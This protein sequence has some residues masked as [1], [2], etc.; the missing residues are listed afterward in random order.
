MCD[1]V[2][3]NQCQWPSLLELLDGTCSWAVDGSWTLTQGSRPAAASHATT[4]HLRRAA[5]PL[6]RHSADFLALL[7]DCSGHCHFRSAASAHFIMQQL[8]AEYCLPCNMNVLAPWTADASWTGL[9]NAARSQ[10]R[11]NAC[12]TRLPCPGLALQ[13]I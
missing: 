3:S 6:L 1:F 7:Q 12:F 5:I 4:E 10:H 13:K 9:L 8:A 2:K 11:P